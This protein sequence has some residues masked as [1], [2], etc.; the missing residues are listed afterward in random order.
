MAQ[1]DIAQL[2]KA[3]RDGQGERLVDVLA[4]SS[5]AERGASALIAV[6]EALLF[7]RAYP[8]NAATLRQADTALKRLG[9]RVGELV[10]DGA[11]LD[12]LEEPE[13]SGIA[14]TSISAIFSYGVVRDLV[15]RHPGCIE[16]HWDYYEKPNH[17]GRELTRFLPALADDAMVEATV[18]YREW[19]EQAAGERTVAEWLMER[20]SQLPFAEAD[21]IYNSLELMLRWEFGESEAT[22]TL[23]RLPGRKRFYYRKALLRRSDVDFAAEVEGPAVPMEHVEPKTAQ[24]V[25]AMMRD[26]SAVRY[27]ELHGFTFGDP[28]N[29]FRVDAGRGLEIYLNGVPPEHRLPLRAYHSGMFFNNGVPV[30]YVE[31]L[32]LFDRMEVGF[33]LYYTFREGETARLYAQTLRVFRQMLGIQYF[34]IDPYQIGHEN[35]EAIESGAYWFYRKLGFRSVGSEQAALCAREEKKLKSKKRYRSSAETLRLLAA[36]PV[37]Y[38]AAGAPSGVWDK[39]EARKVGLAVTRRMAEQFAGDPERM[40]ASVEE[41]IQSTFEVDLSEFPAAEGFAAVISLMPDLPERSAK[42]RLLAAEI[43]RTKGRGDEGRFLRLC[44]KHEQLRAGVLGLGRGLQI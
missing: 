34:S 39:F 21:R 16:I 38:E 24:A 27:R 13:V 6:H 23:G 14:G 20:L 8:R 4:E 22:R 31:G 9:K 28:K 35:E 43:L 42:E 29:M 19:L 41:L 5:R 3:Y 25:L 10:Q 11:Y 36:V 15:N 2:K 26:T 33:N 7:V 40:R 12:L 37:I 18:P 30:G 44:Q 17:L 32:S 1:Q